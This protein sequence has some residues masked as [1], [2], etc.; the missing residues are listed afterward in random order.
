MA[1]PGEEPAPP[2]GVAVIVSADEEAPANDRVAGSNTARGT[3]GSLA[4]VRER[5]LA[6]FERED[7]DV[8]GASDFERA[9]PIVPADGLGGADGAGA[10]DIGERHAEVEE[11]GHDVG[12]VRADGWLHAAVVRIGRDGV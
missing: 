1:E 2:S 6:L 10:D 7:G 4:A 9:D 8:G 3:F 12:H 5:E 11:F